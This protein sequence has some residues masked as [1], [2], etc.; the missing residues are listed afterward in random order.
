MMTFSC[1]AQ[2]VEADGLTLRFEVDAEDSAICRLVVDG[3]V[4]KFQRNGALLGI[5]YPT[6]SED[7]DANP[8]EEGQD[9]PQDDAGG[10]EQKDSTG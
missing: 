1:A 4:L 7:D 10:G 5:T 2:T 6:D 3:V 9:K 8:A